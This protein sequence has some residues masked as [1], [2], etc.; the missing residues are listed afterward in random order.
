MPDAPDF[1]KLLDQFNENLVFKTLISQ[2][3]LTN[4][5]EIL[6]EID[7]DK[8]KYYIF[9]TDYLSSFD[10]ID[11]LLIKYI[12]HYTNLV[13]AKSSPGE[14]ENTIP[15]K[16]TMIYK[17]PQDWDILGKYANE[18]YGSKDYYFNFLVKP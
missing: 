11:K 8:G 10:Y 2:K 17:K 15:Y 6:Y 7:T 1:Q 18:K 12:G 3:F 16:K 14:F 13:E 4:E 9:E 5:N